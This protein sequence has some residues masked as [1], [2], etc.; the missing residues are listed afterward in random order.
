VLNSGATSGTLN[1]TTQI[2]NGETLEQ[3]DRLNVNLPVANPAGIIALAL[4]KLPFG[5]ILE[6]EL[7]AMQA[8]GKGEVISSPKV[9]TSNQSTALI[10]SGTEIPF[11]QAASSGATAVE[12]K[13]AVLSLEV[14]PQITPDDQVI[15]D[16]KVNKDS[17]GAT[18]NGVPSINTQSV[19][20]QLLVDNGETVVLGGVF[21][22]TKS[23][24]VRRVP[25]FS[26]LPL[27]GVLFRT[28]T[29]VDDKQ[30]L[31]IFVTPKIIKNGLDF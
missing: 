1:G 27:V 5:A 26:D 8:E 15:M 4:A 7:S 20:T 31:L 18:F 19:E 13:K 22:Q 25:F 28:T 11:Q 29:N 9:I 17:V 16:L 30:E 6:L 14:T 24:S 10:E 21:E 3:A 12:F 2:L 23:D